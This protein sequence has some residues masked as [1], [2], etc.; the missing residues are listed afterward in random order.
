MKLT[1]TPYLPHHC[2]ESTSAAKR[3]R[4][5]YICC[6]RC[7]MSTA[8]V[9]PPS[10]LFRHYSQCCISPIGDGHLCS[11]PMSTSGRSA[12]RWYSVMART[13]CCCRSHVSFSD[14]W[15]PRPL[16]KPPSAI[17]T[18]PAGT[19]TWGPDAALCRDQLLCGN[20]QRTE[21]GALCSF[22]R[23]VRSEQARPPAY[24]RCTAM[25]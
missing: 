10:A 13:A 16:S 18:T 24:T 23:T 14:S 8:A 22:V 25:L 12:P 19:A 6:Y 2:A 20:I 15:H 1:A 7:E 21:C 17:S 11:S 4:Q 9:S 5:P 3:N